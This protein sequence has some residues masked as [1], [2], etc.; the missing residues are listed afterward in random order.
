MYRFPDSSIG[1]QPIWYHMHE[2]PLMFARTMRAKG[3]K[4][5][6]VKMGGIGHLKALY[7]LGLLSKKPARISAAE[8]ASWEATAS[9]LPP[10]L[11]MEELKVKTEDHTITGS[12]FILLVEVIGQKNGIR[13]SHTLWASAPNI[14]EV[15]KQYPM[16]THASFTFS[17]GCSLLALALIKGEIETK[18]VLTPEELPQAVREE[19]LRQLTKQTPPNAVV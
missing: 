14:G 8:V 10:P 16:A 9:L 15:M 3:L 1:T 6:N 7:E 5:C 11:T 18:G 19:F 13:E 4:N 2:E 17:I 12:H